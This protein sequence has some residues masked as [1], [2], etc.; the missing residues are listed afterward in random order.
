MTRNALGTI[1]GTNQRIVMPRCDIRYLEGGVRMW[2]PRC[3]ENNL[4]PGDDPTRG[5]E[6]DVFVSAYSSNDR[7]SPFVMQEFLYEAR[8]NFVRAMMEQRPSRR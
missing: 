4:S 1:I 3:L 7:R 5:E 6:F 2:V 8:Q